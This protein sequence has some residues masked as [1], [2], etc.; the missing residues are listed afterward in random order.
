MDRNNEQLT[1]IHSSTFTIFFAM[2][3]VIPVLGPYLA[4]LGFSDTEI[5]V[6]AMLTPLTS[7]LLRPFTGVVADCWSRKYLVV[8]GLSATALSGLLYVSPRY[9]VPLGR[10]FQGIGVAFYVPGSIAL[11]SYLAKKTGKLGMHMGIRSLLN[12]LGFTIGPLASAYLTVDYGFHAPFIALG[13]TPLPFIYL[14]LKLE[15]GIEYRRKPALKLAEIL[16]RWFSMGRKPFILWTTVAVTVMA[17]GYSSLQTFLS[18]YYQEAYGRGVQLAGT[19]FTIAGLSSIPT[20]AGSGILSERIGASRAIELAFTLIL[21]GSMTV[22]SRGFISYIISPVFI[23]LGLGTLVPSMLVGVSQ[24][25]DNRE[26]GSAFSFSTISWDIGGLIGP[27]LGGVL[28]SFSGYRLA[29][30]I[31]PVLNVVALGAFTL[32]FLR[33]K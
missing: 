28:S 14:A 20:R 32:Y 5:G 11:T 6:I 26:Y 17:T 18:L 16:E 15:E 29:I 25:T 3:V 10:V 22:L 1:I 4:S 30:L 27:L 23:G 19:F 31:Y 9:I 2:S 13:L 33:R 8:V 24:V 12:G 21:V 7:M